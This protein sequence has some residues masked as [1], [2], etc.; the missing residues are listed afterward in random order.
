[1]N[2]EASSIP[3]FSINAR[4]SLRERISKLMRLSLLGLSG[5]CRKHPMTQSFIQSIDTNYT[6][7]LFQGYKNS[8]LLP[9]ESIE[10]KFVIS[11]YQTI[12]NLSALGYETEL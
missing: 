2:C 1:M 4:L 6:V 10:R 7:E 3:T 5:S 11:G 8:C 12:V 9:L